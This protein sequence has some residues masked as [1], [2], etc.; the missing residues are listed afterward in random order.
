L[1]VSRRFDSWAR[2]E[3][4][5]SDV[6]VRAMS[7]LSKFRSGGKPSGESPRTEHRAVVEA[8]V[9]WVGEH[10]GVE[11]YVE[12]KT[13]MT[14]VTMVLIAHDGEFTRKPVGSPEAA[15]AFARQNRLPIYDA[16]IVGYPQRMRDYTRRHKIAKERD[17][18][19]FLGD[20]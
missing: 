7:W 13:S 20:R 9:L 19:G 15:K 8:L 2:S 17:R 12:P 4:E 16:T 6:K 5:T 11:V 3:G 10:R 18:R 1:L 14:P